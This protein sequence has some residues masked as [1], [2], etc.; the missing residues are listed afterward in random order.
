[1]PTDSM[2]CRR[3]THRPAQQ[4]KLDQRKSEEEA[5]LKSENKKIEDRRR[6]LEKK[7]RQASKGLQVPPYWKNKS[8][9]N[10]VD[11]LC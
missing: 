2:G 5:Q 10:F 11:Q 3:R 4:Q 9:I 6:E 1:M 7:E 8:G